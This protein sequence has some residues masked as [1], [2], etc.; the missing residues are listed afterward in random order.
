MSVGA[1][2]LQMPLDDGECGW[3]QIA[4]IATLTIALTAGADGNA[5]TLV[6]ADDGTL[7]V[8]ALVTDHICAIADDASAM[9][10]V[11]C[12]PM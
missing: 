3:I 5:L 11:C 1:G 10:I 8:A 7:D 9:E 4:G 6:G 2:V 12:F